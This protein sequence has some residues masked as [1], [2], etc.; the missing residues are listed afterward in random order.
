MPRTTVT[1]TA[2]KRSRAT[3]AAPRRTNRRRLNA[4]IIEPRFV[5]INEPA[6]VRNSH[7]LTL[8]IVGAVALVIVGMWMWNLQRVIVAT[9]NR[10]RTLAGDVA[11]TLRL[12]DAQFSGI[13]RSL[14][15]QQSTTTAATSTDL[16]ALK[17]SVIRQIE[18]SLGPDSWPEHSSQPLKLSLRYPTTWFKQETTDSVIIRSYQ[19]ATNTPDVLAQVMI[20]RHDN[21][22]RLSADEYHRLQPEY[23]THIK[24]STTVMVA[25][26]AIN[27][28][29]ETP[30]DAANSHSLLYLNSSS[31][32]YEIDL[33]SRNDTS[34]YEPVF[35]NLLSTIKLLP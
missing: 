29:I 16:A 2:P 35:M 26:R 32:I 9:E 22:T 14:E 34:I 25:G 7:H 20:T 4:P 30:L 12:V 24:A 33:Y 28:Y 1:P 5:D 10:D 6:A 11:E 19:S 18:Q 3:K 23:A 13:R 15:S 21:P 31:T 27:R 8:I 17:E